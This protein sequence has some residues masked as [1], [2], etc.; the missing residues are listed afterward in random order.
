MGSAGAEGEFT[1]WAVTAWPRLLRVATALTAGDHHLAEDLVQTALAK[2]FL[3][4][5]RVRLDE[6]RGEHPD[7]YVHRVLVRAFVDETRRSWWRRE[8]RPLPATDGPDAT[9]APGPSFDLP[10]IGADESSALADV[11]A[12]RDAL[13]ALP[14]DQ[15]AAVVLRYWLGHDVRETAVLLRCPE[16]T[17]RSRSARGLARLRE[18][19]DETDPSAKG[20][21][22]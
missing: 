12:V 22:R 9:G 19:L 6:A 7:R 4:W 17:V 2:T 21:A 1:A 8:R 20:A 15:R 16:A 11:L 10:A 3:A 18:L 14:A 13:A 5:G